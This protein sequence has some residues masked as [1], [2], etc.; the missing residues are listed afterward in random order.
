MAVGV[1]E[2][3]QEPDKPLT[4]QDLR[5]VKTE[6]Y[7]R[8]RVTGDFKDADDY[9]S[10]EYCEIF[11]DLE[12]KAQTVTYLAVLLHREVNEEFLGQNK[13]IS[14]KVVYYYDPDG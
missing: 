1:V 13:A 11:V 5:F 14:S 10:G 2:D 8:P 3:D 9:Y 7:C 4:L 6:T 12:L